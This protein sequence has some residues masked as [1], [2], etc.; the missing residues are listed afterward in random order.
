VTTHSWVV[1][2]GG[3]LGRHVEASLAAADADADI[4]HPATPVRWGDAA[5][6]GREL[7]LTAA[8]FF[9]RVSGSGRPWR[10]FWCA[11]AGVIATPRSA[12]AEETFLAS[13][14]L[15]AIGDRL[16]VDSE[17]ARRGTLFFTSSAGGVYAASGASPPF[18]ESSP[19]AALAPYG[20]EKLAQERLFEQA[21]RASGAGL[22]VGR[23]SNLYGPGQSLTKPQGLVAH[24]G[25][26]AL[27]RQPVSI[28][29]P[30]DTIR[31][32]LFAPDAGRM[33]VEAVERH[34]AA[35]RAGATPPTITKIFASEI[36]TTV[37]SVL[38]AW[39]QALRRPLRVALATNPAGRLQPRVLSFRSRIWPD[40]RRQPTL[41]PLGVDAVRRD[42]LRRLMAMGAG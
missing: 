32:Y 41:L 6:A 16:S 23:L 31:D 21:A 15:A 2:R 25:M 7:E 24:V 17:L 34:E 8:Q 26:A 10:L 12:L 28:Y 27:R 35:R 20:L 9:R 1:G 11:G 5:W 33:V 38:H 13:R 22:V 18:D 3:L 19:V 36:E 40:V 4:W 30:L 42:Q 14:F 29:V 39:R 37:A